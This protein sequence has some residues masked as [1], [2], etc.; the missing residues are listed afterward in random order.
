[1]KSYLIAALALV[2][3]FPVFADEKTRVKNTANQAGKNLE[4]QTIGGLKNRSTFAR[5]Y[6]MAGCGFG[7]M[8]MGN[9]DGQILA[10]TT[11]G[12]SFNQMFGITFGT[13]N[14]VGSPTHAKADQ[15]DQFMLVN[16]IAFT[17]DVARE[18]GETLGVVAHLMGCPESAEIGPL[19]HK[20]FANIF[21]K[22][23]LY[24]NEVTDHL[25]TVVGQDPN[26]SAQCGIEI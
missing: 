12:T 2:F 14:C 4:K 1:M 18:E 16:R 20:N 8:V 13:L 24:P 10:A 21:S 3:A 22:P 7:S 11:N 15:I 25:L 6:G 19:L 26:L 23:D 5:S 17:D 9:Q